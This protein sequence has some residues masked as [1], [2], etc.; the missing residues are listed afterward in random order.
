MDKE[1]SFLSREKVKQVLA[2]HDESCNVEKVFFYPSLEAL[3]ETV[4]GNRV[5]A[6]G[7]IFVCALDEQRFVIMKQIAP[8]SCEMMTV[9]H[10]GFHDVLTAYRFEQDEL[11]KYVTS[12]VGIV[13]DGASLVLD[14]INGC[15]L[16]VHPDHP[17]TVV[18]YERHADGSPMTENAC[19]VDHLVEKQDDLL[20]LAFPGQQFRSYAILNAEGAVTKQWTPRRRG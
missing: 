11:V 17:G 18:R 9:T 7:E 2:A 4:R 6:I 15:Y 14:E 19:D 3:V 20:E 5:W 8:D 13:F 10:K 16:G 12:C 1:S